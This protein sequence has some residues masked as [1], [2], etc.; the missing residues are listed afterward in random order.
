[1][2]L[3][4]KTP[5][6]AG[7]EGLAWS[8]EVGRKT[9]LVLEALN[10]APCRKK[11]DCI[12]NIAQKYNLSRPTV[13]RLLKQYKENGASGFAPIRSTRG[14]ARS[15]SN[16]A[17]DFWIGLVLKREHRKISKKG[18][19]GILE[20]EATKKGWKIGSYPNACKKISEHITPQL[21]ALQKGGVRELDNSLPPVLRSYADLQ[22]FEIIVGD[23]HR[24]DFWVLDPHTG[25]VFRP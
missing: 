17:L 25:E 1:M 22:P 6:L 10:V 9:K 24:F 7:F 5:D 20:N 3:L 19:Y 18:L 16:E 2:T 14:V 23:Q 13:Y 8:E 21:L 12:Q 11:G 4:T 15:W